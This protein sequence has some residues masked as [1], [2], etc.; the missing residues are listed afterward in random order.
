MHLNIRYLIA[1]LLLVPWVF[2]GVAFAQSITGKWTV[3]EQ[4]PAGMSTAH[5][6][7]SIINGRLNIVD[8]KKTIPGSEI[9]LPGDYRR[10]LSVSND[11]FDGQ[12]LSFTIHDYPL[13]E[14][15]IQYILNFT[16]P[17]TMEGVFR[18]SDN[19]GGGMFGKIED[20]GKVVMKRER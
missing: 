11:S 8:L 14:A 7:I 4:S 20:A 3:Y 19:F 17:N 6:D 5:W 12:R 16:G 13:E 2:Y 9:V 15:T 1:M 18:L 10:R